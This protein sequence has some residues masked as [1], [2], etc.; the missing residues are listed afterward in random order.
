MKQPCENIWI[1]A[2]PLL[3]WEQATIKGKREQNDF[4]TMSPQA[5]VSL[6]EHKHLPH[7]IYECACGTGHLSKILEEH[8]HIVISTD[9]IESWIWSRQCQFLAGKKDSWRLHLHFD[10][11]TLQIHK[12]VCCSFIETVAEWWW[13]NFL[14]KYQY[15][16]RKSKIQTLLF[17]RLFAFIVFFLFR[18]WWLIFLIFSLLSDRNSSS[19]HLSNCVRHIGLPIRRVWDKAHTYHCLFG[20]TTTFCDWAP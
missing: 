11:S 2:F 5:L 18:G 9:L 7:I 13:S 20:R 16:Y 8:G 4:Y 19:Q 3:P 10:R 12:W 14:A 1:T 15:T 17:Q 6:M